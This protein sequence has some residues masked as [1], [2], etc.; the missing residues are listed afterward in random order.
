MD[1]FN[2]AISFILGLVV[3][4][5]FIAVASGRINLK[6]RLTLFSRSS[7]NTSVTSKPTPSPTVTSTPKKTGFLSSLFNFGKPKVTPT[8]IS[9]KKSPSPTPVAGILSNTGSMN[10][11]GGSP[12]K[13]IQTE[14]YH[15]YNSVGLVSSIPNTGPGLLI[16][17][18]FSSLAG[19]LLLY[20][21]SRD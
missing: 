20:K 18:V 7:T 8:P 11:D 4:A 15:S 1:Q 17:L 3:V 14:Q 2:K 12:T 5:V 10:N 6:D 19:G 21:K 13:E 9:Q 16:P